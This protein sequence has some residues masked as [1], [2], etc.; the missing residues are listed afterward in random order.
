MDKYPDLLEES[1]EE[2]DN[3]KRTLTKKLVKSPPTTK[4]GVRE[5]AS[6]IMSR[7]DLSQRGYKN[8]KKILKSQNVELPSYISVQQ[9]VNNL[10][11]GTLTR[12]HCGCLDDVCLSCGSNTKETIEIVLKNKAW[13]ELLEFPDAGKQTTFFKNL[14]TL[15][16]SLY[17]HLDPNLRTLFIRLTGDNFRAACKYP[18]EQISF[19]FLNNTEMLH[20]P[21]GQ[22]VASLFRGSESRENVDIHTQSH[23]TEIKKLL[24]DGII[25]DNE[26]FNVL[27]TMCADLCFVKEIVGKCSCTSIFGCFFCKK[28]IKNWDQDVLE[29]SDPQTIE[30][31]IVSGEQAV[32]VLGKN[33]DH[34]TKEFTSFQQSHFG[35]YVSTLIIYTTDLLYFSN[36][37][38]ATNLQV[39]I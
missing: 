17:G 38:T 37:V 28:N 32:N 27:P 21:Y 12:A 26:K 9:F 14:A 13:F 16:K 30:E 24:S 15:N 23:Y 11:L 20:S 4:I 5:G 1:I 8:V 29:K 31:M 18:T 33:P 25:I 7:S 39:L 34:S 6:L 3:L 10:E 35:Q 22:F 2:N 36:I 19:S